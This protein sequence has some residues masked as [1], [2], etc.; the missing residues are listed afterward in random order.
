MELLVL[1]LHPV[2]HECMRTSCCKRVPELVLEDEIARE[3]R[4]VVEQTGIFA[5][6]NPD[7]VIRFH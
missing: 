4:V 1:H 3:R 2:M 5:Q 7:E 6:L